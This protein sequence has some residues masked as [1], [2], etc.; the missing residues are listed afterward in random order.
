MHDDTTWKSWPDFFELQSS[1][2]FVIRSWWKITVN[3]V[4]TVLQSLW[5]KVVVLK[6]CKQALFTAFFINTRILKFKSQLTFA[7]FAA[8]NHL[9]GPLRKQKFTSTSS[10]GHGLWLVIGGFRSVLCFSVFQGSLLVIVIMIDG[11][12]KR[13]CEGRFWTSEFAC[14]Q[15]RSKG[16]REKSS[17]GGTRSRVVARLNLLSPLKKKSL[18][19]DNR[20]TSEDNEIS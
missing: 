20:T 17:A 14:F 8:V 10:K 12:K 1:F 13:T 9:S 7:F 3:I 19:T 4:S 5:R 18:L 16:Y 6:A 15:K 2:T 11:S